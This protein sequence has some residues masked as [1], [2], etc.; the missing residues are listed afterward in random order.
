MENLGVK[1]PLVVLTYRRLSD[2]L[3]TDDIVRIEVRENLDGWTLNSDAILPQDATKVLAIEPVNYRRGES[4]IHGL[5]AL[6]LLKG[7]SPIVKIFSNEFVQ[8]E[9]SF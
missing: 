6:Y 2:S 8:I 9:P 7:S 1:Y 3:T 4:I 5:A